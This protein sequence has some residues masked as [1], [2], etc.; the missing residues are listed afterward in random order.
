MDE[1]FPTLDQRAKQV[2]N[3]AATLVSRSMVPEDII[4]GILQLL[5]DDLDLQNGQVLLPDPQTKKLNIRHSCYMSTGDE[6]DDYAFSYHLANDVML[7][8]NIAITPNESASF[9]DKHSIIKAAEN[10]GN[11]TRGI[12]VPISR[13]NAALG[14]LVVVANNFEPHKLD[15]ILCVLNVMAA[16]INQA[17]L[18]TKM[19]SNALNVAVTESEDSQSPTVVG[20]YG[21]F[22]Y[23]ILGQSPTLRNA[24]K[25]AMRAATS[26]SAVMIIGESGTGKEKFARMIHDSSNRRDKPFIYV[27]CAAIPEKLL[28][29]KLFGCEQDNFGNFVPSRKGKFELADRGTLFLDEIGEMNMDVQTKLLQ[30]LQSNTIQ[31]VGAN[32]DILVDVRIITATYMNLQESVNNGAFRLD[33]YYRLNVVRVQLP[34]LRKRK[35]DIPLLTKYFWEKENEHQEPKIILLPEIIDCLEK[36]SW[37][38]NIRQLENVIER[39]IL[40]SDDKQVTAYEIEAIIE[41]ESQ[42]H[43]Q[44]QLGQPIYYKNDAHI[45]SKMAVL[46]ATRPYNRVRSQ[47]RDTIIAALKRS[48][49]NKTYAAKQLGLTPRQLHYRLDKLNIVS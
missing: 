40:M 37:P 11:V 25:N 42:I 44:K 6:I 30:F 7:T 14:V 26:R 27:N 13:D 20:V 12:A 19:V 21:S 45:Q 34:P 38:G 2:L 16:F 22:K 24:I 4:S 35:G 36:Y 1:G 33:L 15:N 29:A 5:S 47:E 3:N 23:G 31:R 41:E 46:S 10:S 17:L 43:I 48:R 8:N 39:A 32:D 9:V 28:E 18:V 49:G